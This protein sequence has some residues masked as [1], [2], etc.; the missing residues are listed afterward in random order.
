MTMPCAASL[1]KPTQRLQRRQRRRL[2][3]RSRARSR[4]PRR[5]S[6]GSLW[7][8]SGGAR[9]AATR[10]LLLLLLRRRRRLP[11]RRRRVRGWEAVR[12]TLTSGSRTTRRGRSRRSSGASASGRRFGRG[13]CL[14]KTRG[15]GR[16]RC[17]GGA[18][19][20]R[21][22]T[23]CAPEATPPSARYEDAVT[24]YTEARGLSA[25]SRRLDGRGRPGG[26]PS[27]A[28]G[29]EQAARYDGLAGG[30][31]RA[32]RG[33]A[34]SA[35]A[36]VR[37]GAI[38]GE[39]VAPDDDVLLVLAPQSMVGAPIVPPLEA[40]T[41]AAASQGSAVVLI[42][43]LLQDR[44]SSSGVMGVRGRAERLAFAESF[45]EIYH[46][47]LLYSGTTFMYPILG[48]L[49]M[50]RQDGRRVLYRRLEGA[51]GSATGSADARMPW[52]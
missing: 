47:R 31:G 28:G 5:S 12:P 23:R 29:G 6:H 16:R 30:G 35:D 43:P 11:R 36:I 14:S 45:A 25:P 20:R 22:Q 13:W 17:G 51:P 37:F 15:R 26:R 52:D 40:L 41:E 18:R 9:R 24:D 33:L 10:L 44:Q 4:R 38:G 8:T 19:A 50:A 3:R 27:R 21:G 49:R 1:R 39:E 48:A 7:R 46:F 32:E 34:R 2:Q 42:N